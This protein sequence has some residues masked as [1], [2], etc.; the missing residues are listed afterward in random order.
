ML[1]ETRLVTPVK[2]NKLGGSV[3]HLNVTSPGRQIRSSLLEYIINVGLEKVTFK[4]IPFV[5]KG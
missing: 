4:S 3:R 1:L 5:L 2:V